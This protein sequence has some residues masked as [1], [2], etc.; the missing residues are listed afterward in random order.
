MLPPC[1]HLILTSSSSWPKVELRERGRRWNVVALC[2]AGVLV[3]DRRSVHEVLSKEVSVPEEQ[4][5]E[6]LYVV[7]RVHILLFC[8][9][10][11]REPVAHG[12]APVAVH[13]RLTSGRRIGHALLESIVRLRLG[14]EVPL[15]LM[16]VDDPVALSASCGLSFRLHTVSSTR[17]G[18]TR[19]QGGV[20][21]FEFDLLV[22]RREEF[23]EFRVKP[24]GGEIFRGDVAGWFEELVLG[25][26]EG[27]RTEV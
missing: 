21:Q 16:V 7:E 12:E 14:R 19:G 23:D 4:W 17:T 22:D 2:R 20:A 9:V 6:V 10:R 24:K 3:W 26:R 18:R 1:G 11:H 25:V 5:P 8:R 15:S 27:R 13:L